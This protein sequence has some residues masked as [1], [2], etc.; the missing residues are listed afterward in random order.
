MSSDDI[1][2]RT[3][4]AHDYKAVSFFLEQLAGE[5][6][7][8]GIPFASGVSPPVYSA[9]IDQFLGASEVCGPHGGSQRQA[10]SHV[11][12]IDH[13]EHLIFSG[14]QAVVRIMGLRCDPD[15]LSHD[16]YQRNSH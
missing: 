8:E 4:K 2:L 16:E 14:I 15:A 11:F 6:A 3:A 5:L 10:V 1:A 13:I 9:F 7:D 12:A